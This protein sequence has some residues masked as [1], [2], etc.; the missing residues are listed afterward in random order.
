MGAKILFVHTRELCYYSG[1][2]FLKRMQEAVSRLGIESEY[3]ALEDQ[4]DLD[5]FEHRIGEHFDGVVDINSKLPY[6]VLD[7]DTRL[8]DALDAPFYN[9]IVDHPLYH[10]PGLVFPLQQYHAI[11][12]DHRHCAYMKK[13]YPHLQQVAFLPLGAT[14]AGEVSREGAI[15]ESALHEET[16]RDAMSLEGTTLGM[17]LPE[18]RKRKIPLLVSATYE[19]GDEMISKFRALCYQIPSKAAQ[20]NGFH[21]ELFELGMQVGE[22]MLA[23]RTDAGGKYRGISGQGNGAANREMADGMNFAE[24]GEMPM[25]EALLSVL[26]PEQLADGRFGTTEFPVLMN[27][28]YLIDKYVRNVRRE[29]VMNYVA[30][31]GIPM[32]VLGEGWEA[33]PLADN[34]NVHLLGARRI[35]DTFALMAESRQVLDINP[36]FPEGVHDRVTSAMRNGCV[37]LSDMSQQADPRLLDG[38]QLQYYTNWNLDL[39][40]ERLLGTSM[41]QQEK[42]AYEAHIFAG[43]HYTWDAHARQLL[44][45]MGLSDK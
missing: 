35:E 4:Q 45:L 8:L 2:F 29:K 17:T 28:L 44:E 3:I 7:D 6:F 30:S 5:R 41:A 32:V 16:L 39:L 27:Y 21:R 26:D 42:I 24:I 11:G 19:R 9:Y 1:S 33:T 37:C 38:R 22:C 31:L 25:E 43:T 36:L 13:H 10:H 18:Y 14:A 40:G 23:G 12:I 15:G 34:P 20:V